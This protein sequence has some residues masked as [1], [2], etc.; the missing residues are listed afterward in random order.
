MQHRKLLTLLDNV[1]KTRAV[2]SSNSIAVS[3]GR[4][5]VSRKTAS[6]N[7]RQAHSVVLKL[8]LKH[9]PAGVPCLA[10]RSGGRFVRF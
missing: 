3:Y 6:S 8:N 4:I 5:A 1:R 7:R 9:A 10:A 2:F